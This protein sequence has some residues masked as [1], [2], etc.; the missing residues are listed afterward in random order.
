[1]L[2]TLP[3]ETE[4]RLEDRIRT[5]R[6][7]G[8]NPDLVLHGGGN[9]SVKSS[10]VSMTGKKINALFVK[11][12][13]SD[14]SKIEADGFT[15]LDLDGL[16][17]AKE[18]N[19]MNDEDMI[20]F[21]RVQMLDP[22]QSDPS[23]ET[24]LHA[25]IPFEYVDHSH[26]DYV[27]A[28]TNT[29]LSDDQIKSIF[30]DRVVVLPYIHPG[31]KLAK[32]FINILVDSDFG[33][34][35]GA[36]LRN[37]GLVTW[38]HTADESYSKHLALVSKAESFVKSRWKGIEQR[39]I[40]DADV[41]KFVQFLPHIRGVLSKHRKKI[42]TWNH[43][44]EAVGYS[45]TDIA[46][47][48][49][50]LGP[51]TPDMLV[52]TKKDYLFMNSIDEAEERIGEYVARYEKNYR[53][54]IGGR[55]E[56]H[57]PNP[58]V[59]VIKGYGIITASDTLAES[60]ITMDFAIHSLRV[61]S[62]A[63][64]IGRNRFITEKESFEMEYWPPQEAKLRKKQRR[65]LEGYVALIT[66]AASGIGK[67]TMHRFAEEGMVAVG[68]DIDSKIK[69]VSNNAN[70]T[71]LIF[72]ITNEEEVK[73]AFTEIV[74]MYGG[75]D[76]IFNNAGYLKP[77]LLEET[78]LENM[79]KHIE[80][81]SIGTFLVTREAF[82]IMKSQGSGGIFIFNATKNVT[83]PGEGMVAY[84]SSKAFVAQLARYVAIEGGKYGIR[85]NVLNPDKIFRESRIWE[86]GVLE[87]RA[88]AK[89]ISVEEYKKANLLHVEVLPE[90]VANVAI[91]LVKDAIFG[92]TTGTMI[93]IDG[94]I[95]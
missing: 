5:S 7:M 66:G 23:V 2:Y 15:T 71:G 38:G 37:H 94:G 73:K 30:G 35:D 87:N 20:S 53:Q 16:I 9:T 1:M 44:P 21:F 70:E 47:K 86:G 36:I 92:A 63:A 59:I 8:S 10:I 65:G 31:F 50:T 22:S 68:C 82:K 41:M 13:G 45:L 34:Y 4:S 64:S 76:V 58:N 91:E 43:D 72:D 75:I 74:K 89:G 18:L 28:I 19:E 84:G 69:E 90:H 32:E 48:L 14:L 40:D 60:R 49:Q 11:G 3:Y 62:A 29:D 42:I 93:P 17:E 52:R 56:M 57:D 77:S 67:V 88:K 12:S 81:N 80:V 26:A 79:R 46:E 78:S 55:Y 61:A 6:L 51:A 95:K 54:Y 83:H 39:T 24:F 25:F 33:N 27:V 85:S